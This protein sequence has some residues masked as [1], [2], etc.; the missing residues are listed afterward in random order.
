MPAIIALIMGGG[1]FF[2]FGKIRDYHELKSKGMLQ[3]F[4]NALNL[5]I[6]R[7]Y[8]SVGDAMVRILLMT[9]GNANSGEA[10][11]LVSR[12]S[13]EHP[14]VR[15][16]FLSEA[17]ESSESVPI[18]IDPAF[19]GDVVALGRTA[20]ALREWNGPNEQSYG[21]DVRTHL[22]VKMGVL[23]TIGM[24][25]GGVERYLWTVVELEPFFELPEQDPTTGETV[26][27]HLHND[28]QED[29]LALCA[30]GSGIWQSSA[31]CLLKDTWLFK[32]TESDFPIVLGRHDFELELHGPP[33]YGL[34]AFDRALPPLLLVFGL[35]MTV[36]VNVVLFY[37]RQ[38]EKLKTLHRENQ[39]LRDQHEFITTISHQL[40]TPVNVIRW[41]IEEMVELCRKNTLKGLT[42]DIL[43]KIQDL[44]GIIGNLL[45][46]VESSGSERF[47]ENTEIRS[48]SQIVD[49]AIARFG[50]ESVKK[51]VVLEWS[52]ARQHDLVK[53]NVPNI[54]R[55]IN[56]LV[57]N[58]IDY[59]PKGKKITVEV[60]VDGEALTY[61]VS[62]E[63]I[64]V[65]R[66]EVDRVFEKFFRASNASLEKNTG[67]GVSLYIAKKI[68]EA[69]GGSVG[70]AS[71]EGKGSTFWFTLP[72]RPSA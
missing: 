62:D 41:N 70:L 72:I 8:A 57:E 20:D 35:I 25:E 4:G 55:A 12:M 69:H 37:G 59:T 68:V 54:S 61:K 45:Y 56:S 11:A 6:E 53:V 28:A 9:G 30:S 3:Q 2:I 24:S 48:F 27:A 65:P 31:S 60:R 66:G 49:E 46:Y 10:A 34:S 19:N 22:D 18:Y 38:R 36:F 43:A 16:V 17:G 63:G 21:L 39:M 5:Q 26:Y 67:S 14:E 47:A 33:G 13:Q 50:S 44:N 71:V 64:G 42:A 58:A 52:N 40:R 23:A 32:A 1:A 7:N 15:A 51:G 29:V